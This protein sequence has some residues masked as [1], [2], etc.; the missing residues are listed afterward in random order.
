MLKYRGKCASCGSGR[1]SK[2]MKEYPKGYPIPENFSGELSYQNEKNCRLCRFCYRKGVQSSSQ[3]LKTSSIAGN[4]KSRKV[5]K[6]SPAV[7]EIKTRNRRRDS[8]G[9]MIEKVMEGRSEIATNN[10]MEMVDGLPEVIEVETGN[11][12]T[13]MLKMR[14]DKKYE[15]FGRDMECNGNFK[16]RKTKKEGNRWKFQL[17]CDSCKNVFEFATQAETG[18][19]E[20]SLGDDVINVKKEDLRKV[21]LVL[22]AGSTYAALHII[23]S[24]DINL[25]AGS[26]FYAIQKFIC[27]GIV[28]CCNDVLE[29]RRVAL[30][31]ELTELGT[32]WVAS[33]NGAW[34]HR[35]WSARQHTFIIRAEDQNEVICAIV[36]TKKHVALINAPEG[37]QEEKVVHEGNYFGTSKGMEGEAFIVAIQQ[38]RET[39][40]IPL[41][42]HVVTDG[43]S[44]I[45]HI[46]AN[47]EDMKHL[48]EAK[49][50]G[51]YQK[52]FMRSL[53]DIFGVSQNYKSFPYRIG[54]FYMRCLKRAESKYLGHDEEAVENRR[55]H[56]EDLWKYALPHYTNK[57]CSKDCPCNEFYEK[58]V[59]IL[60]RDD[61]YAVH[62]LSSL[63]DVENHSG[64]NENGKPEQPQL[65]LVEE[66]DN[67]I[68]EI[69]EEDA[70][71]DER[72][73][74]D[75]KKRKEVKK[76]LDEKNEK[77]KKFIEKMTPLFESAKDCVSDVLFGLNTCLSECSNSRRLVFC[78]KDRFYYSSYE[79]RSL[80][81]AVL[82]NIDRSA[83]FEK[84]Y[85]YFGLKFDS[86]DESV[87]NSLKKVDN[88]KIKDS[89][90]KKSLEYK[91]RQAEISKKRIEENISASQASNDRREERGYTMTKN[92]KLKV[93]SF[94]R[95]RGKKSQEDLQEL[96]DKE[97]GNVKKCGD[98]GKYYV[99]KHKCKGASAKGKS[100]K[101]GYK[102]RK[103]NVNDIPK[104]KEEEDE[105]EEEEKAKE[106]SSKKRSRANVVIPKDKE[107]EEE[108]FKVKEVVSKGKKVLRFDDS[109]DGDEVLDD[110][111]VAPR[112]VSKRNKKSKK[113]NDFVNADEFDELDLLDEKELREQSA[114]L[115]EIEYGWVDTDGFGCY[116]NLIVTTCNIPASTYIPSGGEMLFTTLCVETEAKATKRFKKDVVEQMENKEIA[117]LPSFNRKHY[118]VFV[119]KMKERVVE[120]YDSC[121]KYQLNFKKDI[122]RLQTL[123]KEGF[124]GEWN[125]T[126]PEC[127][128]QDNDDD[129]G[130]YALNVLR[131]LIN[132][133]NF[134]Y[135]LKFPGKR[136]VQNPDKNKKK[137]VMALRKQFAEEIRQ[138]RL[139]P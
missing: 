9:S 10:M 17:Q 106:I 112:S 116:V 4:V 96:F 109:Y 56:F 40:L 62:A 37:E 30:R 139:F 102:K 13:M 126:T 103:I 121:P 76:W 134:E 80:I 16:C 35:G 132:G 66:K 12:L 122:I 22:L 48:K 113:Q 47:N 54:K 79:A 120:L 97:I 77:E 133:S 91:T 19:V 118:V 90:R 137:S 115:M 5:G 114:K 127:P 2:K 78:R 65:E 46:I 29:K 107:E 75:I 38:L 81:S 61:I 74:P 135:K 15:K 42:S 64:S 6:S 18:L 68:K 93:A 67:F 28:N 83:L 23:D 71:E 131:N 125:V 100:I 7:R 119:L 11:L 31:E 101:R 128:Q 94:V 85:E 57:L 136:N 53:Q 32:K 98:C 55:K 39:G 41:L 14:C 89:E 45:P 63:I 44:S 49:D 123:L 92:K 69:L 51:H 117:I 95:R 82:E 33:M 86:K 26:T 129:C 124:G 43:D 108:E 1:D 87:M 88:K 111:N 24:P 3:M 8:T 34:S 138:N 84:I 110:L 60:E 50:P 73:N 104:E 36:L 130:V 70:N 58:E 25:M 105:E 21:L 20:L 72:N 99:N 27:Q 52:N 59:E